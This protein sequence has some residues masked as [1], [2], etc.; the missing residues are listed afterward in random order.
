MVY[1]LLEDVIEALPFCH[2]SVSLVMQ[3]VDPLDKIID[4]TLTVTHDI[5][6]IYH[7]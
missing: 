5:F 3:I 7:V 2:H 6:F 1:S 4:P